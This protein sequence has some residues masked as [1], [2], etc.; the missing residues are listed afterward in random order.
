MPEEAA[1]RVGFQMLT[2]VE[3]FKTYVRPDV[4]ALEPAG[5]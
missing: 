4:L 5:G 3:E 1:N 2:S